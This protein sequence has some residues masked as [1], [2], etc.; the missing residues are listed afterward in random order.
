MSERAQGPR[1]GGGRRGAALA[2]LAWWPLLTGLYLALADSRRL[3]EV[4]A[5][6]AIGALGATAAVLVRHERDVVL[7]PRPR[8]VA[9]ELLR[10]LRA[11]PRDLALLAAALVRR[12][13]GR[14]VEEPFAATGEDPRDGARRA[15]AV[16]GR[17]L[18]PNEIVI[19]VD[20]D[21]GVIVSHRLVD[22]GRRA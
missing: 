15:L 6:I 22:D 10:A 3:E 19:V 14:V 21:R 8:W 1:G 18:A 11:W 13:H 9:E 7:R 16:A 17:S 12:P 5:G 4:V 2:W 20:G